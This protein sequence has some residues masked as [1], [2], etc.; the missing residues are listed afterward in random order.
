L[1]TIRQTTFEPIDV[2]EQNKKNAIAHYV[3]MSSWS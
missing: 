3:E 2:G 1:D